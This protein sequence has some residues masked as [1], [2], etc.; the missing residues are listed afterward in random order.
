L[1]HT[2]ARRHEAGRNLEGLFTIVVDCAFQ[3]HVA[4]IVREEL[5]ALTLYS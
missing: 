4:T 5:Q 1:A 3:L 2:K